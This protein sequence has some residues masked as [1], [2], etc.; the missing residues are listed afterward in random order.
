MK[1]RYPAAWAAGAALSFAL[2][3][4]PAWPWWAAALFLVSACVR[5]RHEALISL[6]FLFGSLYAVWRTEAALQR[7]WPLAAAVEARDYTVRVVGLPQQEA[8][9]TAFAAELR[10]ADG[11]VYRA[12]LSDYQMRA[13]PPGSVWQTT[14]RLRPPVGERNLRGF[15]REAQALAQGIDALGTVGK[16]R[17]AVMPSEKSSDFALARFSDGL[18]KA[19]FAVGQSWR[20]LEG[21]GADDG[22]ALMRAL[23]I[24]EQTALESRLWQA[25]RP[26]GLN[27]LVSISGLHISLIALLAAG[28]AKVL[29]QRL[30]FTPKRPRVWLLAAGVS[31][32][33]FYAAMAGFSVPTVRAVLMTAVL[34]A[35]WAAGGR[36]SAWQAWIWALCGVLL[37]DPAAVLA[38]GTWLSFGLV[39]VLLWMVSWRLEEDG[40]WRLAVR[41]Q[42]AATWATFLGAGFLFAAL[43]VASPLA[44]AWAVP[45]FSWVLVPLALA[46]SLL[47]FEAVQYAG[48]FLGEYTLRFMLWQAQFA[49]E[50]SVAAAPRALLV[51]AVPALLIALL[52][53]GFGLKPWAFL[54]LG[55]FFFYREPPP[56]QNAVRAE[57][58]DVGQGLA[59][60]FQTA[61]KSLLFDTGTLSAAHTQ[62]VPLLRS[63]GVR[64]LD[65]LVLSHH[66]ADHDGGAALIEETFRPSE[67]WA[68]QAEF[69]RGAAACREAH[70]WTWDGVSFEFLS[71]PEQGGDNDR[72][73]VLRVLAG[74]KAL[75]VTGDLGETGE[76]ALI[77]RY[78]AA[79]QSRLLVLG[80]HGSS[81]SSSGAFLHAVQPDYGIASSGFSNAFSHPTA[82][83]QQRLQ[84]HGIRLLRTDRQGALRFE[85]G[86]EP[87]SD[88]KIT[89]QFLPRAWWQKKP[90]AETGG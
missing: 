41:G 38:A 84:A 89:P 49:P 26:L 68:G 37:L 32:A 72:S 66:D 1:M 13:W 17:R 79:L 3:Q 40:G 45:W 9:R 16:S 27:H 47:P 78:G 14:A 67:K 25:F 82:V 22:T 76:A 64:R 81:G 31:A 30:P 46:G 85:W 57:I 73:C 44:N 71:V 42:W 23:S 43:P 8:R 50:W 56:E 35:A 74:G 69:Y 18:L 39:A 48:A 59:V 51:L 19:R 62:T 29:L 61:L 63:R 11:R 87:R 55:G 75:M 28:L 88:N 21:R 7:Q 65:A 77:E 58:I 52:P 2:P 60:F 54:L 83:V 24:G 6:C 86:A 10:S 20:R 53:R 4:V 80:H 90:M 36:V 33:V 12:R 5:K 15:S 34:A 70:S